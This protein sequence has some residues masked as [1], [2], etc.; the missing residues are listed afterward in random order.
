[1]KT[2]AGI[3]ALALGLAFSPDGLRA[4]AEVVGSQGTK[5]EGPPAARTRMQ[6]QLNGLI[7]EQAGIVRSEP[8]REENS[9]AANAEETLRLAPMIVE[10]RRELALPPPVKEN[11]VQE[12][13]RTGTL[14]K[15]V[16]PRFT[17]RFWVKGDE[18]IAFTLSW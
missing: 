2:R 10:G 12:V 14:W 1:M 11:R 6:I 7:R 3:V 17:K 16:G 18:G 13:L 15:K 8:A 4:E 5:D 9:A